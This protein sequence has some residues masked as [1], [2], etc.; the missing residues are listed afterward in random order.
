MYN[1]LKQGYKEKKDIDFENEDAEEALRNKVTEIK[2]NLEV[3]A[4]L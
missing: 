3:A 1:Y 4:F 2:K